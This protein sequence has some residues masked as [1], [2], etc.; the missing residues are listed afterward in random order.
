MFFP[1]YIKVGRG[2]RVLDVGSGAYPYRRADVLCDKYNIGD[3]DDCFQHCGKPVT[4]N[5]RPFFR[6][7]DN[8]LPFEDKEF[9]LATCACV[10]EHVPVEDLHTLVAEIE[11]VAKSAY[12]EIPKPFYDCVYN[13][14]PHVNLC[15]ILEDG[16]I[17]MISKR[18]T[19][20][21]NVSDFNEWA[22][23]MRKEEVFSLDS[24]PRI[25][26]VG[27]MYYGEIPVR[28]VND[29]EE[30]WRLVYVNR[31]FCSPPSFAW[32]VWN[33]IVGQ[34]HKQD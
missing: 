14:A 13:I 26:A 27:R 16:T 28:V 29:E 4:A 24:H 10:L 2:D 21:R 22:W 17:L 9:D 31:Y 7:V 12:I 8:I 20:L 23:Q 3:D 30:F 33:R 32:K 19:S 1:N 11:R 5:D 6:I 25:T 15:D 34:V 18:N